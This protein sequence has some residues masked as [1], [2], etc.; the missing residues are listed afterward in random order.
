[1]NVCMHVL[2]G[3]PKIEWKVL[4]FLL[5]LRTTPPSLTRSILRSCVSFVMFC[6][7]HSSLHIIFVLN[8]IPLVSFGLFCFAS[9]CFISICF[10]YT[11][12]VNTNNCFSFIIADSISY[13]Y[14]YTCILCRHGCVCVCVC[15]F[16]ICLSCISGFLMFFLFFFFLLK[17][18]LKIEEILNSKNK[19]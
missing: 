3:F 16:I 18:S 4:F 11:G 15:G 8:L 10:V 13:T 14:S 6:W 19:T 2:K 12:H 1:M 7:R 5:V 17:I 9:F